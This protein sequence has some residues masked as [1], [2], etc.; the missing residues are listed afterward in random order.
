MQFT[1]EEKHIIGFYNVKSRT[2]LINTLSNVIPHIED[3]ELKDTAE[4]VLN[5]LNAITDAEFNSMD[6]TEY[7]NT[8]DFESDR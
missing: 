4:S 8:E 5:K 7:R 3:A 2:E 6:F 1:V